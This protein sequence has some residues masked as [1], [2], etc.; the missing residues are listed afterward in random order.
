MLNRCL[1][2]AFNS[3]MGKLGGQKSSERIRKSLFIIGRG[4]T[5]Q[6]RRNL[7]QIKKFLKICYHIIFGTPQLIKM[8]QR[9]FCDRVSFFFV[10]FIVTL[11]GEEDLKKEA[12]RM[13][14]ELAKYEKEYTKVLKEKELIDKTEAELITA[15][16]VCRERVKE[17]QAVEKRISQQQQLQH[18]KDSRKSSEELF[19]NLASHGASW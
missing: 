4:R 17:Q 10:L 13:E 2:K 16:T 19:Q 7:Q 12:A 15:M 9:N 1:N 6:H 11:S 18:M 5:G 3:I 8:N 14:A